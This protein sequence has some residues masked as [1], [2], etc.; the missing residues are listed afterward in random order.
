M[1][2]IIVIGLIWAQG[3]YLSVYDQAFLVD[4]TT[5]VPRFALS[6][7][8]Y[9]LVILL[10]VWGLLRLEGDRFVDLGLK[11]DRFWAQLGIGALFGLGLFILHQAVLSPL[12]D[13]VVP[14]SAPTGVDLAPLLTEPVYYPVW[15]A[16]ALFKGGFQEEI[17]RIFALTRFE[18]RWGRSGLLLAIAVGDRDIE[19]AIAIDVPL[20]DFVRAL[21]GSGLCTRAFSNA[22]HMSPPAQVDLVADDRQGSVDGFVDSVD[23]ELLQRRSVAD[24]HRH[25][26]TRRDVDAAIGADR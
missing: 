25:S 12:A 3:V 14:S 2:S 21:V 22:V 10:I 7:G 26:R 15:V 19:I 18:K 8:G 23:R 13:A 4:L 16:L 6:A 17:W 11:A 24:H 1:I 20:L 9:G 5:S